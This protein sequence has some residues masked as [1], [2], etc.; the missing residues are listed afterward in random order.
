MLFK[1]EQTTNL[2]HIEAW[3]YVIVFVGYYSKYIPI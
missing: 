3:L 1:I 2:V